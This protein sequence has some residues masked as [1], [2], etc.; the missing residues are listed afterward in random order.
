MNHQDTGNAGDLRD[1]RE[2]ALGIVAELGIERRNDTEG[3]IAHE[4]RV[5][6]GRRLRDKL[7]AECGCGARPVVDHDLLAE[8]LGKLGRDRAR[9]DVGPATRRERD[10]QPYRPV[11]I[12]LS[13]CSRHASCC[14][15]QSERRLTHRNS[16]VIQN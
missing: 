4:Q 7:G 15:H 6:I 11:G 9:G 10:D 16:F 2:V 1:R 8:Q 14:K 3:R 5:T 12:G 13:C